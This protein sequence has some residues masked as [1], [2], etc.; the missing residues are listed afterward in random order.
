MNR[1]L[2]FNGDYLQEKD[3]F[4]HCSD[5]ALQRGYGIFDFC[6]TR[7]NIPLYIDAHLD[8][9]LASADAMRLHIRESKDN[10]KGIIE[11]LITTNQ[12]ASS[13]IKI[14]LTG[15]YSEDAYSIREP[16]LIISQQILLPRSE[17]M[18]DR[19]MKLITHDYCR[20][21]PHVKTINY[22]MGIWLQKKIQENGA[23]DVLYHKNGIISELP[24]ANFF[25][26]TRDD[27]VL[28]PSKNILK[29]ITRSNTI[30][31]AKKEFKVEEK[32][33]SLDDLRSAKEAFLS[34]TTKG[35]IAIVQID[36]QKIGSGIPGMISKR[37]DK[38]LLDLEES[39]LQQYA[40]QQ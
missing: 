40:I 23:S 15:G 20:E 33:I 3:A 18:V 9:F 30:S 8:R 27:V 25:M 19:G 34:S 26:V 1:I 22:S 35:I 21:F 28:T 2:Y 7:D 10:L 17:E 16:N 38:L 12:V 36:G 14:L 37:L 24:R 29:G 11:R 5:L 39:Y 13:G 6:K 31:V 4:V 32:D